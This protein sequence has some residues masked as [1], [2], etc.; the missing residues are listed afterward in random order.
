[1]LFRSKAYSL[2]IDSGSGHARFSDGA[3][4]VDLVAAT[5]QPVSASRIATAAM[6]GASATIDMLPYHQLRLLLDAVSKKDRVN[7]VNLGAI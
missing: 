7:Y 3:V 5:H 4:E 6:P 2:S 1:M